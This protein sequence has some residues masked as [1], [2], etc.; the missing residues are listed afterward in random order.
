MAIPDTSTAF[1][2]HVA[3]RL[4]D[5]ILA[6]LTT[7]DARG[8]PQPSLIWF[9]WNGTEILVYSRPDKP[10]L[11]NIAR[12]PRVALNL[13]SDGN[14]GDVVVVTGQARLDPDGPTAAEHAAFEAKYLKRIKGIGMD[15]YAGFTAAFSETIRIT[16]E[17][18]RGFA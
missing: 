4:E 5:D 17:R 11:A 3:S 8:T 10:K 12:N 9:V 13:E 6:W 16:P 7:V 2:A 15:S 18:L 1:G 14:G